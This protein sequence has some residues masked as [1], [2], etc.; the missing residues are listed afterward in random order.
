MHNGSTRHHRKWRNG[1]LGVVATVAPIA[2][3]ADL[4]NPLSTQPPTAFA[5]INVAS[6]PQFI[7]P[8]KRSMLA[9][10]LP[11][12]K[13]AAQPSIVVRKRVVATPPSHL[14]NRRRRK[15]PMTLALILM[16]QAQNQGNTIR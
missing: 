2:A 9:D 1:L 4:I 12:S 16:V 13:G 3:Y 11:S 10:D 8:L 14:S 6:R 7:A 15:T 5:R